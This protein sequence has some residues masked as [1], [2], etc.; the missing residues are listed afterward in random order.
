[1]KVGDLVLCTWQ[2]A[3]SRVANGFAMPMKHKIK[4][5][6]GLIVKNHDDDRFLIFFP[7]FSYMHTLTDGAFEVISESR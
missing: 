3:V 6:R 4:G 2:P 7:K 1:M 5:E